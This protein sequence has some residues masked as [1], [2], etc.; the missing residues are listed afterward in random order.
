[1]NKDIFL[2]NENVESFKFLRYILL[3]MRLWYI[4][5]ILKDGLILLNLLSDNDN[6]DDDNEDDIYVVFLLL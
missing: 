6:F 3:H 2:E 5:S 4:C 1:L